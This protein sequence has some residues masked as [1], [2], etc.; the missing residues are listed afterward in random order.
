MPKVTFEVPAELKQ[1]MDRHP[2]INWSAVFRQSI[3]RQAR[4][5]DLA[6]QILEEE[7]DPRVRAI[8]G[9]LKAGVSRRYRE[10]QRARRR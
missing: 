3:D 2:E 5:A 8:A 10:G 9:A 1:L 6:R 4:A 7:S